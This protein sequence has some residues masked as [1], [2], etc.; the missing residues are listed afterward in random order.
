MSREEPWKIETFVDRQGR[1]PVDDWLNR[2]DAKDRTRIRRSLDLL[3]DYGIQLPMPYAR[4]LRGKLFELR[5]QVGR[6]DYRVHYFAVVG[7]R[8]VLLHG[9]A[10]STQKTPARESE[11]AERRMAEYQA[12][13]REGDR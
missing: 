13:Q 5:I 3:R 7:R 11:T 8:M 9:F 12:D 10:K 2:L 6:R 4:H 1:R